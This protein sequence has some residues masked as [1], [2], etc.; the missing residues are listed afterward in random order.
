M[1]MVDSKVLTWTWMTGMVALMHT[2]N[3]N[4]F[5]Q[6][7]QDDD[8]EGGEEDE[9][10]PARKNKHDKD[11]EEEPEVGPMSKRVKLPEETN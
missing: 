7:N 4:S 2:V 6:M 11:E 1:T 10:R 9:D 5:T 3:L 8:K